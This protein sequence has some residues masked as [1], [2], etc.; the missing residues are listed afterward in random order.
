MILLPRGRGPGC[1]TALVASGIKATTDVIKCL[2]GQLL[3]NIKNLTNH[4]PA[5]GAFY[6]SVFAFIHEAANSVVLCSSR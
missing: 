5:N 2:I 6:A 3:K 4:T 1:C